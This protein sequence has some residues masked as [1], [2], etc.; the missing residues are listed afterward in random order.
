MNEIFT[1]LWPYIVL[2]V[3]TIV[4]AEVVPMLAQKASK[5]ENKLDDAAVGW[6]RR[7]L[8]YVS[9]KMRWRIK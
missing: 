4:L 1:S 9:K 2:I 6:V 8:V 3:V 5:T 7:L